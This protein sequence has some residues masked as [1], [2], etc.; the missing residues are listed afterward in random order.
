M[1]T[2]IT[3]ILSLIL[4][5]MA[6]CQ[7]E[8]NDSLSEESEPIE[9]KDELKTMSE[10]D[11]T[12][13]TAEEAKDADEP[14]EAA[15]EE[16]VEMGQ[17][18]L[19][20]RTIVEI[21]YMPRNIDAKVPAYKVAEDL[22]NIVNLSQF[23]G[24]NE[25]QKYLLMENG[26]FVLP[27]YQEQLFYI[28]ES[29]EYKLI[30]TFVTT[31]SV[32]QVYH[33]FYDYSLRTLEQET[34]LG[35]LEI[36]NDSLLRKMI[37]LHRQADNKNVQDAAFK[38]IAY[39]GTAQLALEKELPQEMPEKAI[40]MAW[41]EY[42]KMM[43]ANGFR[44]SS[45]FGFKLDYSQ[46]RPRGHYTRSLELERYFK[47][48]MWYGQ[49]P[50]SLYKEDEQGN[51][52]RDIDSTLQA[53]LMSHAVFLEND[54]EQD[55]KL[56]E[57]IYEPTKFYVGAADDLDVYSYE[58]IM[59]RVYGAKLILDT[60]DDQAYIDAFYNEADKLPNPQISAEYELIDTPT[61][62]QFRLMGQRFIPDSDIMQ[63][64]VKAI[65]RPIPKGL[66]VMAALGSERAEDLLINHYKEPEK[67]SNYTERL[68]QMK[69]KY[70]NL[71]KEVWRSNMYYGWLWTLKGFLKT[72][73]EGY[74]S[75]MTSQAWTDKSLSTA[76]GSWSELKHD[77][78]L[79]GKQSGAEC[80][81]GEEPPQIRGYVEPNIEVYEKL[82][83]LN[84]FSKEN[85]KVRGII[86]S[87]VESKLDEFD[88]LLR[89]LIQCSEKELN[90]QPLTA[91]ENYQL[92]T[93]G[94]LLEYL[95]ASFAGDGYMRWFEITS[96]TDKNMAII[97]DVHTIAPDGYLEVGVGPAHEIYVVVPIEGE[98]YLTRGAVFSY[99]EFTE[100][101]KRLTD[102]EWQKKIKEG[103]TPPQQD[104]IMDYMGGA[105][106]FEV[107]EPAEPYSSGC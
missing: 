74:P 65:E 44:E 13:G 60:M 69:T 82:L 5:L 43:D 26:F 17:G 93:Y 70:G 73:D 48:M 30:P 89:F 8:L 38:N 10:A 7:S 57:K 6:G 95:T 81:G 107:P 77:T 34:L 103:N 104:W 106:Q 9:V 1:R 20:E 53:M 80:G 14:E 46:Y 31:D 92:L 51:V 18:E 32:L 22:S 45:I 47:T 25:R 35:T 90:N 75:F 99:Y 91:E 39:L 63:H 42:Q 98:L 71:E 79:Y 12:Q 85:L 52:V 72:Y 28:Y 87:Q 86:P 64:L 41:N 3:V 56:W 62:K 40:A 96:E 100:S 27:T 50:M 19:D 67:W 101:G 54:G 88:E 4:L 59:N 24:F 23:Q 49:V 55:I 94:G 15:V 37:V 29:N 78:V 36:L 66:D 11:E 2:W 21:P 58:T 102:E 16:T 68:N 97:S 33:V 105:E 61:A 84:Q 83:W 76:L